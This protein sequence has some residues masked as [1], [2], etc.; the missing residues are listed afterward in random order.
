MA[1]PQQAAV[2]DVEVLSGDVEHLYRVGR[3]LGRGAFARLEGCGVIALCDDT[4]A[5]LFADKYI[6]VFLFRVKCDLFKSF[7]CPGG[8]GRFPIM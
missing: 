5:T 1:S 4:F 6:Y 8:S 2:E 3:Q 7:L